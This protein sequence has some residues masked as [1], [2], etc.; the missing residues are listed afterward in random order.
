MQKKYLYEFENENKSAYFRLLW[1]IVIE[2]R[3]TR[4]RRIYDTL[5][6][7]QSSAITVGSTHCFEDCSRLFNMWGEHLFK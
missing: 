1:I 7:Y 5:L 2:V 4:T 3:F 6:R